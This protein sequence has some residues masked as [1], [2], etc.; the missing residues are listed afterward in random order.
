[1]YKPVEKK[2]RGE[3]IEKKKITMSVVSYL[4]GSR[5]GKKG[6]STSC[7][8]ARP[9]R[10]RIMAPSSFAKP[11][12]SSWAAPPEH[13]LDDSCESV[14]RAF[15]S[16]PIDLVL[17]H[18]QVEDKGLSVD[19]AQARLRVKGPNKLHSQKPP[20]WFILLLK[21][22][23]NPFNLLLIFLAIINASIPPPDWV[24]SPP[25]LF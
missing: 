12:G 2:K 18:L 13:A 23:P 16:L 1:M 15:A 3:E 7:V 24:S 6:Y 19:E 20:S 17:D 21:V 5:E 10:V 4:L 22:I 14:L 11:T 25:L 8:T 9:A